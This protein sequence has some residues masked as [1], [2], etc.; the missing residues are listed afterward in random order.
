MNLKVLIAK[1]KPEI[2]NIADTLAYMLAIAFCFEHW[3]QLTQRA[4][5]FIL[6]PI[7]VASYVW[8]YLIVPFRAGLA[9]ITDDQDGNFKN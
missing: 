1:V 4:F 9:G 7:L 8:K 3:P 2:R 5:L 6:L